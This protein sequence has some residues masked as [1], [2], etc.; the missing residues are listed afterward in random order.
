M[1]AEG[2]RANEGETPP[3]PV[4]ED[5]IV[6]I[7]SDDYESYEIGC[8]EI[9]TTEDDCEVVTEWS[10]VILAYIFI[11]VAFFCVEMYVFSMNNSRGDMNGELLAALFLHALTIVGFG[12]YPAL[13]V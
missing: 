9:P 5:T 11:N 10:L 7:E 12:I 13:D 4:P 1:S 8:C 2:E 6:N 3:P